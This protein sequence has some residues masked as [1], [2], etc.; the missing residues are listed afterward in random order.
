MNLYK[1]TFSHHAPKDGEQGIKALI[2]AENDE[3]VFN[4]IASEPKT[5]EGSMFNSWKDREEY[6]WDK[7]KETFVDKDGD[8]V[9]EGWWDEDGN[10]ENFK[11]RMLRLKGE[12]EDD[13][14]DFSDSYYGIT[15]LGW[16]L[17]KE[18]VATDYSELI[19][20]GV[21]FVAVS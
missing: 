20:L 12:I 14:V 11:E 13:S 15:L 9:D 3:Q 19:E 2:L 4:W 18:N 8:E 5:N 6:S 7:E 16:E 21:V 17:L 10:P 1:V